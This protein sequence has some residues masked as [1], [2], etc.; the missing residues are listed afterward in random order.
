MSW[1]EG[2][3]DIDDQPTFQ[4]IDRANLAS[5]SIDSPVRDCKAESGSFARGIVSC[6][7]ATERQ[8]NLREHGFR[9]AWLPDPERE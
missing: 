2:E 7:D 5:V 9:H 3:F 6:L 8:K 4:R 1:A